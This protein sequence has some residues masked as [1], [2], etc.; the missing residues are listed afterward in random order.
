[1]LLRT[2]TVENGQREAFNAAVLCSLATPEIEANVLVYTLNEAGPQ[3]TSWVYLAALAPLA[4]GGYQ[5]SSLDERACQVARRVLRQIIEG[6]RG[7][8]DAATAYH[9]IRIERLG[10]PL[11]PHPTCLEQHH[12]LTLGPGAIQTLLACRSSDNVGEPFYS[13]HLLP[14][15]PYE[16]PLEDSPVATVEAQRAADAPTPA[17]HSTSRSE[18]M[19]REVQTTLNTLVEM[20]G[21]FT[22]RK[23]DSGPL[24]PAQGLAERERE[25]Q[26]Q[27]ARLQAL[28]AELQARQ[29]AQ[30]QRRTRLAEHEAALD[31]RAAELDVQVEK[32]LAAKERLR[33]LMRTVNE[34]M[35][36]S[37]TLGAI[38]NALPVVDD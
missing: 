26:A 31:R 21:V 32:L 14:Y 36:V 6:A 9:F 30:E 34:N 18:Q 12:P 19:L 22:R 13:G 10:P 24:Q 27:E 4:E 8:R 11:T 2:I 5:L 3:G 15:Q 37:N 35:H 7:N 20:A 38:G 28:A 17:P 33:R 23:P 1:M 29:D 25:L 16:S